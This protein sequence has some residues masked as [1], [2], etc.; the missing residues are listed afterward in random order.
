MG[1]EGG[2]GVCGKLFT[3]SLNKMGPRILPWGTPDIT[4][5]ESDNSEFMRITCRLSNRQLANQAGY[6]P[7]TMFYCIE[8]LAHI[9]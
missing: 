2:G 1:E 9:K 3:S 7:N 6:R 8:S 5:K 4:G